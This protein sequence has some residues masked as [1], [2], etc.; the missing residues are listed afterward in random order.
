M[1]RDAAP[2]SA[3]TR[4]AAS[5]QS[6]DERIALGR[7][8]VESFF[9]KRFPRDFEVRAFARRSELD[10]F[11]AARWKMPKTECWMVAMGVASTFVLLSPDCWR[12]DACE[13][14]PADE[15]HVQQIVTHELTHVFHGQHNPQPEFDGLD[16]VGWFVEGLAV[17]V[18]G[19]LD[20]HRRA[21]A[22]EAAQRGEPA[23]LA[24]AWSGPARYAV[25]GSLVEFV[26]RRVGRAKTRELLACTT[27]Q[28]I[29]SI[30]G[31]DEAALLSTWRA[32]VTSAESSR[33]SR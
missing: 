33:G 29:L 11:A 30:V 7:A 18:S 8:R 27:P 28:Q 17:V 24:D 1:A 14:N 26:D 10:E 6:L 12:S 9:A 2:S 20:E 4:P 23:R 13:H 25:S 32:S 22:R 15:Q 21:Q 31:L 5:A 16:D 3:A 19:Q